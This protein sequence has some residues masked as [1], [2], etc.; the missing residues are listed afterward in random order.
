VSAEPVSRHLIGAAFGEKRPHADG[1]PQ[2][3][4]FLRMSYFRRPAVSESPDPELL[5]RMHRSILT[6]PPKTRDIFIAHRVHGL[7]SGEIAARTGLSIRQVQQHMA[8]AILGIDRALEGPP[9]R[10]WERLFGIW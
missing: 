1:D 6:L 10:W 9:R 8:K 3:A 5:Q 4:G 7:S 2:G